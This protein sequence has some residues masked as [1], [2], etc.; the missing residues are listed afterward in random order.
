MSEIKSKI[1]AID[2][3][4]SAAERLDAAV[5]IEPNTENIEG[6]MMIFNC[7]NRDIQAVKRF[8]IGKKN[9]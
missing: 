3:L 4:T 5:C 8:F 7:I 2:T 1:D 9:N 6:T